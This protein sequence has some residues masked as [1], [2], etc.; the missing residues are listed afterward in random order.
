[1]HREKHRCIEGEIEKSDIEK[2]EI[3]TRIHTHTH[4]HIQRERERDTDTWKE[5]ETNVQT[6]RDIYKDA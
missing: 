1:M 3:E 4:K 2:R 6:V 5:R